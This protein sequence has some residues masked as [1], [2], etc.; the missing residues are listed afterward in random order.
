MELKIRAHGDV[1][2]TSAEDVL[3]TSVGGTHGVTYRTV[4]GRSQDVTLGR[5]QD[6]DVLR[7]LVRDVSWCYI[8]D[9]M[10]TSIGRLLGTS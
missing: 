8:E 10:G 7:A 4:W 9:N 2:I 6:K 3:K 5:A 1:F